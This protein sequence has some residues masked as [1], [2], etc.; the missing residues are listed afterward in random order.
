LTTGE[1][2]RH[3]KDVVQLQYENNF[4]DCT[5]IVQNKK[6]TKQNSKKML[7]GRAKPFRMIG[8]PDY[9]PPDKWISTVHVFDHMIYTLSESRQN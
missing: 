1:K 7:S 4:N 8:D 5:G 9:Q 2:L 6:N 3:K